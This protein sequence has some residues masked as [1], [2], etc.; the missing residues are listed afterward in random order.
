[1]TAEGWAALGVLAALGIWPTTG[2]LGCTL[3]EGEKA[4]HVLRYCL[5]LVCSAACQEWYRLGTL[6][7]SLKSL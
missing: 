4:S 2:S 6:A 3:P 5:T 7:F 1:M